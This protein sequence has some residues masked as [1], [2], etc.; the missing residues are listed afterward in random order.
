MDDT[1]CDGFCT[2]DVLFDVLFDVLLWIVLHTHQTY[3]RF[4]V[5]FTMFFLF[6][7]L[8]DVE[9]KHFVCSKAWFSYVRSMFVE[10]CFRNSCSLPAQLLCS[11]Y[12]ALHDLDNIFS[13]TR[14]TQMHWPRG[15]AT[16]S[17]MYA[18]HEAGILENMSS[19]RWGSLIRPKDS[20]RTFFGCGKVM[21]SA[22][23]YYGPVYA[24]LP[25]TCVWLRVDVWLW[26]V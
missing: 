9:S 2:R 16:I 20:F 3:L 24:L 6:Y 22:Q 25:T 14:M 23:T 12:T 26:C 19:W 10:R 7:V 11:P 1:R 4:G 15:L 17:W 5:V 8:F 18:T 21:A 13:Y